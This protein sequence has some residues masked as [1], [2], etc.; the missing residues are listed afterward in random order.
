MK[1]VNSGD[2]PIHGFAGDSPVNSVDPDGLFSFDFFQKIGAWIYEKMYGHPGAPNPD[3]AGHLIAVDPDGG[4]IDPHNNVLKS[5]IANGVGMAG[6]NVTDALA[7]EGAGRALGA[8]GEAVAKE[9][10]KKFPILGWAGSKPY[11]DALKLIQRGGPQV[12]LGFIPTREQALQLLRDAGVDLSSGELR[13]EGPHLPP[14]PHDYPHIN[15]PTPTGGKG[16]IRTL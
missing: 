2:R 1:S 16:T 5:S 13:I 9:C 6:D 10:P 3:M 15:Y 12:D 4:G 14:N 11:R 7:M 8:L